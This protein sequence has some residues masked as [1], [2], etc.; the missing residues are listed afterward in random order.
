MENDTICFHRLIATHD[1][2]LMKNRCAQAVVVY[3]NF[4]HL[5]G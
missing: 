4:T 1:R 2:D 3:L 5:R